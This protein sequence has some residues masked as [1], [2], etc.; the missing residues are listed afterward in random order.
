MKYLGIDET[1]LYLGSQRVIV[2]AETSNPELTIDLGWNALLKAKDIL[3][4]EE[5]FPSLDE[6]FEK[7]LDNYYWTLARSSGFSM[8]E[9]QHASI[10]HIVTAKGYDAKNTEIYIDQFYNSE[11]KSVDILQQYMKA[12]GFNISHKKI[13]LVQSG[14]KSIPIINLADLISS[15]IAIQHSSKYESFHKIRQKIPTLMHHIPYEEQRITV[16]LNKS[17]KNA[18]VRAIQNWSLGMDK[19]YVLQ[20][21]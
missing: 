5:N 8:Q 14:D 11:Q 18:L 10:A 9:V 6:M 21:I 12:R 7:G 2:V 13:N 1:P 4:G 17:R 3:N 15:M 16:P 19:K 20:A